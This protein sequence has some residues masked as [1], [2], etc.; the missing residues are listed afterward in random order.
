M[1]AHRHTIRSALL[2]ALAHEAESLTDAV[3]ELDG[4]LQ[5]AQCPDPEVA[6]KA[7]HELYRGSALE[8]LRAALCEAERHYHDLIR[9]HQAELADQEIDAA[10]AV[11]GG[12][13]S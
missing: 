9:E 8:P 11:L 6:G 1:N 3:T 13:R 5:A 10:R 2:S 4:L 7:L 12:R